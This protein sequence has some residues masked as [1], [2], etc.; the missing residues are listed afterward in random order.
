MKY[1]DYICDSCEFIT[2]EL[3]DRIEKAREGCE[4]LGIGVYS[5]ELVQS[6]VNRR[7]LRPYEER[8]KIM[9]YIKGVD[10]VFEVTDESSIEIKKEDFYYNNPKFYSHSYLFYRLPFSESLILCHFYSYY[11]IY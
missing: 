6:Q 2:V 8:A 1:M 9:S 11:N 5:D 10:F 7:P 4:T 3:L